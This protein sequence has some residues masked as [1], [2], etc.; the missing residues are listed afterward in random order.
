MTEEEVDY[1]TPPYLDIVRKWRRAVHWRAVEIRHPKD[2]MAAAL[3]AYWW[4][5]C[6]G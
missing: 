2:D 4:K 6:Q 5:R 3:S 1:I